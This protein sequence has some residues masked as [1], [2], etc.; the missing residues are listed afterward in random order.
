MFYKSDFKHTNIEEVSNKNEHENES[1]RE[2]IVKAWKT[3]LNELLDEYCQCSSLHGVRYIRDSSLP[4]TDRYTVI[5][6]S[7]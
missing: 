2:K 5:Q 1:K 7:L 4:R 6:I 3:Y